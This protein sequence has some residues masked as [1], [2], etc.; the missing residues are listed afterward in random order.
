M[1]YKNPKLV[2]E[3]SKTE[4]GQVTWRSPSNLAIIKYWGKYGNQLPKNPSISI[5]LKNAYTETILAYAPK[6]STELDISLQLYF[7]GEKN[8]SF[9]AK[10]LGYF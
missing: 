9:R 8:E 6:K 10:M 4:P 2:L 1:D 7:N 3:T 5:T